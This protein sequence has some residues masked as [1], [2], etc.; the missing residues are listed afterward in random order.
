MHGISNDAIDDIVSL[1]SRLEV[2]KIATRVFVD[3]DD[4]GDVSLNDIITGDLLVV[5]V[6][7]TRRKNVDDD[8]I[9]KATRKKLIMFIVLTSTSIRD[10]GCE[11]NY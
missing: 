11:S 7:L 2:C 6:T 3:N 8:P 5:E 10:L 9:H 1:A 4:A